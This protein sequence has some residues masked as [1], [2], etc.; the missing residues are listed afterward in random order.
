MNVVL[1]ALLAPKALLVKLVA[2]VKPA[3][4]VP[5]VSL[6]A[7]AALVLMAKLAPL[8]PLVKMVAPDPQAPLVPVVR[9]V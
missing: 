1:L 2:P 6:E 5:R 7:L 8:V 4:L 3:C 9:L